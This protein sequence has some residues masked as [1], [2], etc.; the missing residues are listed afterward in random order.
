[1]TKN[2]KKSYKNKNTRKQRKQRKQT[3]GSY[4]IEELLTNCTYD[5]IKELTWCNKT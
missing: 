2:N 4:T 1:M 5:K 3:G